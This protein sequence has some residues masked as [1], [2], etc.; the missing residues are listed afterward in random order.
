MR[1]ITLMLVLITALFGVAFGVG[2]G[3]LAVFQR[4]SEE[5]GLSQNTVVA[6]REDS[7]GFLWVGTINGLNRFDGYRFVVYKHDPHDPSSIPNNYITAI[8][9]TKAGDLWVGTNKGLSRFD[10]SID[11]FRSFTNDPNDP[12]S[13]VNDEVRTLFEDSLGSFW[14]GTEGGVSKYNAESN[15]FTNYSS[16]VFAGARGMRGVT[17][18]LDGGFWVGAS[19]GLNKFDRQS[20]KVVKVFSMNDSNPDRPITKPVRA[21]ITDRT[22]MLWIGALDGG[23]TRLDPRS[24]TFSRYLTDKK[25]P[26]SLSDDGVRSI[27]ETADGAIWIGTGTAVNR[28]SPDS[29]GFTHYRHDPK[30]I[31]SLGEGDIPT[32]AD[33][34]NGQL[35]VGTSVGGLSKLNRKADRFERF[36]HN[37]DD[38]NSLSDDYYVHAI[39]EDE[40]RSVWIATQRGGLNRFD[41]TTGRFDVIKTLGDPKESSAVALVSAILQDRAGRFW[42]GTPLKGLL[43]LDRSSGQFK[44]YGNDAKS[45]GELPGYLIYSITEDGFGNLW[46][47]SGKGLHRFEPSTEKFKLF[48]F[49][50]N[51]LNGQSAWCILADSRNFIWVSTNLGLH[52][53]DPS[54]QR[55]ERFEPALNDPKTLRSGEQIDSIVEDKAGNLWMA[56]DNGLVKFVRE[57]ETFEYL[58]EGDGLPSNSIVTV[59]V[60]DATGNLWLGTGKGLARFDP[61]SKATR[62]Y[63]VM[64]GLSHS[65]FTPRAAFKNRNGEM[66]F[67]TIRGFV[68]FDPRSFSDS[69]FVPPVY[70]SDLRVFEKPAR[71]TQSLFELKELDI[72]WYENVVSFDFAALDLTDASKLR[73]QWKL[74]GFDE[75][76]ISG[77]TRRTA[78]YTNLPGGEYVLKVRATNVDGV[79][80]GEMLNL[81]VRVKPPFYWTYWF[82]FLVAIL[83]GVV[84]V[85]LFRYRIG[86]LRA[87]SEAQTRF[88]QQ[89]IT[90]QE[91][92]RKRIA[93]ELH[94]G[95]GQTLIIIKNRATLGLSKC[96]DK[97]RVTKELGNISDSASQALEEVREITNNL[98]PQLLDRLGLTKAISAM[99]KKYSGVIDID[100]DIDGIDGIFGEHEEISIYR[101]I[102]ESVNNVI[103]HSN[104]SK[105]DVKV[106]RLENRI[107]IE[108]NDNGRGF[109]PDSLP[110]EKRSFGLAG[111]RERAQLLGGDFV[112]DSKPGVGTKVSVSFRVG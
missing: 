50:S 39:V 13:L 51:G 78:T 64:D 55:F 2:D 20:G 43:N 40:D 105:A 84:I 28:Y 19:N 89:L 96:D 23:L 41:L 106:K 31:R 69:S 22:G 48:P 18:D 99:L 95:L 94:D 37:P 57:N 71:F 92:E 10:P 29:D 58:G 49:G 90:S 56:S 53:L 5:D 70:L 75:N 61:V 33:G 107:M 83:I 66:Y 44:V 7:K 82:W 12:N 47:G 35:W 15:N 52:R 86:Q 63:N 81:I 16:S 79:W 30:N 72:S 32:I 76:W 59:L 91:S 21:M 97:E 88:T 17:E 74:E 77:G 62:T 6:I 110:T 80:G 38:P 8:L 26:N 85:L 54:T 36:R 46:L 98:R 111:L 68:K 101:I 73:Y 34:R 14:V 60:D 100:S 109:D 104:G 65:E 42:L 103:K 108:I 27:T 112:L 24:E 102:Q 67:G 93:A 4:Y 1:R 25:R 87:V 11:G 3:S 45:P 9:E